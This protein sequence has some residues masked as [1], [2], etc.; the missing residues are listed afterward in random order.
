MSSPSMRAVALAAALLPALSV[1]APLTLDQAVDLALGRSEAARSAHAGV[2]SATEAARAAGQLPDPTLSVGVENLPVTGADRFSTTAEAMTM[3]RLAISQEWLSSEKRSARQDAA[4]A[5][6]EREAV[7]ERAAQAETRLQTALAYLDAYYAG[8]TLKLT[9]LTEHHLHEEFE[10]AKGRLSSSAAN[11][12]EVLAMTSARGAAEDESDEVRQAQAT[13]AV[14]LQRWTGLPPAELATPVIS[15]P[16]DEDAFVA[17]YPSVLAARRDVDL[18]RR[19]VA[20]AETNRSSNWT[21]QV[22]YGQRQGYSDLV[23]FGVSI[24]L[25]VSP[26]ERQ[27]RETAARL[28]LVDKAEAALL[29][30]TRSATA[31]YRS[32]A[33]DRQR[34]GG[35]IERYRAGVL[36]P[37]Q[38]RTQAAVAGYRSNQVS[39][40]TVFEARHAEVDVERKLLSL[41]R[42]LAKVQAQL[43][44]RPLM[45][46]GPL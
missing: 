23:T 46:G 42:D 17:A 26:A 31:E 27:D 30:A 45:S 12:Q 18:M 16:M 39:L 9:T 6:V 1:A 19:Q 28:A 25:T 43:A 8:E 34:L 10:A 33:G 22:S 41:Q 7:A 5:A 37:A 15:R 32:L 24:P 3:K 38:Q 20:V 35:R 4:R 11:S 21:W 36:V 13:A 14:A 29:E 44:F 40:M 2:T